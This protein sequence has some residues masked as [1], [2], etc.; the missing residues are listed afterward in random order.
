MYF[1]KNI[2]KHFVQYNKC[3][4]ES[5]LSTLSVLPYKYSIPLVELFQ[6]GSLQSDLMVLSKLHNTD[7]GEICPKAHL[8]TT[9]KTFT[10]KSTNRLH[11]TQA[12][13]KTQAQWKGQTIHQCRPLFWWSYDGLK[14]KGGGSEGTREREGGRE[15]GWR[16]K[17]VCALGEL[18]ERWSDCVA[19]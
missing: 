13:Q 8:I 19:E 4:D 5:S 2:K 17:A 3:L 11:T 14:K 9:K 18:G 7:T 10:D 15:G 1:V 16:D 12:L 6:I